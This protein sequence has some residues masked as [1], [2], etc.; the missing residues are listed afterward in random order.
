MDWGSYHSTG[1]GDQNHPQE[2]EMQEGKTVAWGGLTNRREKD[3]SEKQGEM[4]RYTNLKA[5]VPKNSRRQ[6]SLLV[7]TM[8]RNRGNK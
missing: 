7:W 2:K 6:E 3:R 1:G 4:E 8:K 5:R